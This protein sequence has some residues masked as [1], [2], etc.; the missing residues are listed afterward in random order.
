MTAE[1]N[2]LL[3]ALAGDKQKVRELLADFYNGERQALMDALELIE[4][5]NEEFEY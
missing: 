2:V 5:V 3:A 4:S 1:E